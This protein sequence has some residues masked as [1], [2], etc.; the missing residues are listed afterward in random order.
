MTV[1]ISMTRARAMN[2][3]DEEAKREQIELDRK[4]D[5]LYNKF[6]PKLTV[7][8]IAMIILLLIAT[9][10]IFVYPLLHVR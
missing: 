5:D 1:G 6:V 3:K 10:W 9:G 4:I 8:R 7:R 2:E